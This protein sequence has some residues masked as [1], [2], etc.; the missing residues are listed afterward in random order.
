[1]WTA[2]DVFE[3]RRGAARHY[4]DAVNAKDIEGILRLYAPDAVVYDPVGL[5]DVSSE[6][7]SRC[8]DSTM[9]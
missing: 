1:M 8:S 3:G 6:G 4:V 7:R 9:G 5:P 2:Q